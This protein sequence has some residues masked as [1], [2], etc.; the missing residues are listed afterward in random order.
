MNP[1]KS[2]C[3]KRNIT[4]TVLAVAL[5]YSF[6]TIHRAIQGQYPL[7]MKVAVALDTFFEE[8]V[9]TH[10]REYREWIIDGG[11]K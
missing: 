6:A 10:F 3:E 7:S 2:R 8:P 4:T 11:K 5:G 9:G 1:I